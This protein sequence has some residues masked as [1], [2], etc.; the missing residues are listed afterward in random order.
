MLKS[1][2]NDETGDKATQ[3]LK[4]K[5]KEDKRF[6]T[7]NTNGIDCNLS[8]PVVIDEIEDMVECSSACKLVRDV[9]WQNQVCIVLIDGNKIRVFVDL[10]PN[11]KRA[12]WSQIEVL[13]R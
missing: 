12:A 8:I 13:R 1:Y 9:I 7:V 3:F 4:L 10:A 2:P 11:V 5:L 6:A